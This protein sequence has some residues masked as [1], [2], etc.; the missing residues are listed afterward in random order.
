LKHLLQP[1][2]LLQSEELNMF[3]LTAYV[4]G[5]SAPK[6]KP[7]GAQ[8]AG[9]PVTNINAVILPPVDTIGKHYENLRAI[10]A[11]RGHCLNRHGN[12][13]LISRWGHCKQVDSLAEVE[14]FLIQIG[15]AL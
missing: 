7:H 8:N 13:F 3:K 12:V 6:E 9:E 15:G 10:A 5:Y 2:R 4:G 1:V 11:M 14:A